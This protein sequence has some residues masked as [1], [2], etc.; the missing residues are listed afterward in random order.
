MVRYVST[1]GDFDSSSLKTYSF[2]EAL[3]RGYAPDGG[4]FV[5]ERDFDPIPP[6]LLLSWIQDD[7]APVRFAEVAFCVL[8]RFVDDAELADIDLRAICEQTAAVFAEPTCAVQVRAVRREQGQD[9]CTNH[10]DTEGGEESQSAAKRHKTE[11]SPGTEQVDPASHLFIAELW[12]GP[13]FCFKDLGQ[14]ITMRLLEHFC[15]LRNQP[16]TAIVSTTGDTGPAALQAAADAA[17]DRARNC[18]PGQEQDPKDNAKI[19]LVVAHPEG[20]ISE[21][22]RKQMTTVDSDAVSCVVFEGGGDD[23]DAPIKTLGE[24]AEFRTKIGLVGVNSYNIGRPMAQTVH[25]FWAYLQAVKQ[26]YRGNKKSELTAPPTLDF[27]VPCGALGNLTAGRFAA[28]LGLPVAKFVSGTNVNDVTYRVFRTGTFERAPEMLRN[29]AEAMNIQVPY[30]FERLLWF[31]I[32]DT[33]QRRSGEDKEDST[34]KSDARQTASSF[35]RSAMTQLQTNGKYQIPDAYFATLRESYQ[36][37]TRVEDLQ[38]LSTIRKYH[39]SQNY[40]LCPHTACGVFAAE[41]YFAENYDAKD[42]KEALKDARPC[43]VLATAHWCKFGEV[44]EK[45]LSAD[46]RAKLEL[47]VAAAETLARTERPYA[48]QLQ[49][50]GEKLSAVQPTWT[51]K[52]KALMMA[53]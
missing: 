36:F 51:K 10:A 49:L 9:G 5:P 16:A 32:L 42:A 35:I 7:D 37:S 41:Q 17:R 46:D 6:A 20:Q 21:L 43:V 14:Q 34:K 3:R 2:E 23:L 50:N 24:D 26:V 29:L 18:P 31:S 11:S 39:A 45:A 38:I 22:Q 33:E 15:Y 44:V 47:P 27:S 19:R 48:L 53:E 4:L 13:T 8:R 25:Y 28:R 1:R 52:L 12:H 40:L 30:N